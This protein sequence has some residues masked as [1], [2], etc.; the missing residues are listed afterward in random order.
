MLAITKT[1][2]AVK[3]TAYFHFYSFKLPRFG[4]SDCSVKD[5]SPVSL[6]NL[7]QQMSA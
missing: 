4:V 7:T 3:V 1:V 5:C 2:Y 6:Y